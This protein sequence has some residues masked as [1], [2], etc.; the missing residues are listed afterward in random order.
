MKQRVWIL[1]PLPRAAGLADALH[2]D[3]VEVV[4]ATA[5][6]LAEIASAAYDG[7]GV[8]VL[9]L[10]SPRARDALETSPAVRCVTVLAVLAEGESAP[11]GTLPL[12]AEEAA[13][14][15]SH[16]IREVLAEGSNLRRHP[17]VPVDLD[18]RVDGRPTRLRDASLY[19]AWIQPVEG[20]HRGQD[21]VLEVRLEDGGGVALTGRVVA[22]RGDGAAVSCRPRGEGDLLGWVH[23]LLGELEKSPL[24]P[25]PDP[26]GPLFA[27]PPPDRRR[28]TRD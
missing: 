14:A 16:H 1:G 3:G 11:D 8:L 24:H 5:D 17:R 23:L 15:L 21:V 4:S 20:V 27:G 13:S 9:D 6:D 28:R 25:E 22:V 12:P 10:S 2:R 19:G 18:A 7:Q 26:F